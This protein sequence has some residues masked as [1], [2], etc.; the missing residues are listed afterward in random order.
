[1]KAEGAERADGPR[2][3][4]TIHPTR[5]GRAYEFFETYPAS[6]TTSIQRDKIDLSDRHESE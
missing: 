6:G 3:R 4:S 1:M 5:G 2:K